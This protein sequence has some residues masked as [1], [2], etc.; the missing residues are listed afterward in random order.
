[1]KMSGSGQLKCSGVTAAS[2]PAK[3]LVQSASGEEGVIL[4]SPLTFETTGTSETLIKPASGV[5]MASFSIVAR[6]SQTCASAGTVTLSGDVNSTFK[7]AVGTI[8][9]P[10][11]AKTLTIGTNGVSLTVESVLEAGEGATHHPIALT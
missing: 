9:V 7:G 3:C 1:M 4:T 6:P 11:S 8:N 2:S 10:G 5:T